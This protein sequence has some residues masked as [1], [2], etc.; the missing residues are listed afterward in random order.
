MTTTSQRL[1]DDY[2]ARLRAAAADL[3]TERRSDVLADIAEH[4]AAAQA[5]GMTEEA[6]IRAVLDRLGEPADIV[7]AVAP[8]G[9]R[10]ES[11][12][13]GRGGVETAA[14]VLFLLAEVLF[15][16]VPLSVVAWIVAVVC[17][18]RSRR[19]TP[20]EK[21]LAGGVLA[22]GFWVIFALAGMA[23]GG[24]SGEGSCEGE[25]RSVD[26]RVGGQVAQCAGDTGLT[27]PNY[28]VWALTIAFL[29][30]QAV[31]AWRLVRSARRPA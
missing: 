9:W 7:A 15:F 11:R 27:A 12:E 23:F 30:A 22:P 10:A 21:W 16:F 13:V 28:V 31:V 24:V 26:G 6:Q 8:V 18:V 5:D 3:P 20:G 14:V 19:W 17:L 4:I 25:V 1:V 2:L 29:V